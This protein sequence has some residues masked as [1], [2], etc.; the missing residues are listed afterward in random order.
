[1]EPEPQ[2]ATNIFVF[3]SP[4]AQL[5]GQ[6]V[7]GPAAALAA[8]Y[9]AAP[10]PM[11]RAQTTTWSIELVDSNRVVLTYAG[12]PAPT[13]TAGQLICNLAPTKENEI[14]Y[15]RVVS[16]SDDPAN[17]R[18]TI[19][20]EDVMLTDFVSQGAVSISDSSM[21][22][23]FDRSGVMV[24]GISVGGTLT[25]PRVGVDLSGTEFALRRTALR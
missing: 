18:L 10:M 22:F 11:A 9:P 4:P 20:T 1:M 25:F 17:S 7:R 6:R 13:F 15:R 24:N 21:I 2:T 5:A 12:G 19:M 3:G 16:I 8:R 14:F 23:E